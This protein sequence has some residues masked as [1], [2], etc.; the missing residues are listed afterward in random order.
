[1]IDAQLSGLDTV[2]NELAKIS[3]PE[4]R[5]RILNK[6][7]RKTIS[8][9]KKRVTRQTDVDGTPFPKHARG[10]KRKMLARLVKRLAVLSVNEEGALVGFKNAVEGQIAAKQQFGFSQQ[11]N[12][13]KLKKE[14]PINIFDPAT[15]RQAKALIDAGYKI[16]RPRG[17]TKTPSIKYIVDNMNMGRAGVI[18]RALRGAKQSWETKLPPRSFLGVNEADLAELN[19]LIRAEMEKALSSGAVN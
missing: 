12:S 10:R 7:A 14:S 9:A 11:M 5:K 16:R 19:E 15:R 18:L 3:D 8:H 17:G 1:M 6:A 4:L 13:A 2:V